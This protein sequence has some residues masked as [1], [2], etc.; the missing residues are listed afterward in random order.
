MKATPARRRHPHLCCIFLND[1]LNQALLIISYN[2]YLV[3]A[4]YLLFLLFA[5]ILLFYGYKYTDLGPFRAISFKKLLDLQMNDTSYGWT[6]EMQLKAVKNKL[7][8][9][10]VPVN[11]RKRIGVSKISGTIKGTV[12]AGFKIITTIFKYSFIR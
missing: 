8:V 3:W 5:I 2:F 6:V 12:L 9:M 1:L 10:E 4:V 7:R 11:Y